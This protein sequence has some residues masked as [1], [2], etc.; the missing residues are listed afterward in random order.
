MGFLLV[1]SVPNPES[2]ATDSGQS[3]SMKTNAKLF[4]QST[5]CLHNSK[6]RNYECT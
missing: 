2:K 1:G 3:I 4:H 6:T 5:N